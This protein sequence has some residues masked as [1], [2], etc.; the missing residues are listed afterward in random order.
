MIIFISIILAI[1]IM[2]LSFSVVALAEH[3]P[4]YIGVLMLII[5]TSCIAA[6][7]HSGLR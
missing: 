4:L 1:I 2:G 6:A 5:I 7:I 3:Y